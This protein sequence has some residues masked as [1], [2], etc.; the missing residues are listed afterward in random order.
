MTL[1]I[2][3]RCTLKLQFS[4]YGVIL[5]PVSSMLMGDPMPVSRPSELPD[6]LTKPVGN[7][8]LR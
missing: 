4:E 8:L 6:T 1:P 5:S 7:G 2:S 3:C